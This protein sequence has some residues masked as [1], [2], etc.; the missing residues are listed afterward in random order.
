MAHVKKNGYVGGA[1]II[2]PYIKKLREEVEFQK[3][4]CRVLVDDER[5]RQFKKNTEEH[6]DSIHAMRYNSERANSIT[7]EGKK[8]GSNTTRS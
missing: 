8:N 7:A 2:Y 4:Q 5:T 1:V 6:P 3:F